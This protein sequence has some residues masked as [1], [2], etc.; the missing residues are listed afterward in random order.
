MGAE[1]CSELRD[2]AAITEAIDQYFH[3]LDSGRYE[4]LDSAFWPD[5]SISYD[6][7]RDGTYVG[8]DTITA[9]VRSR[10]DLRAHTSHMKGSFTVT[11]HGDE[12]EADIFGTIFLI[13]TDGGPDASAL[14]RGVHYRD[15]LERRNGAWRIRT[16]VHR[17]L[18]RFETA[19]A[20]LSV[21]EQ[22]GREA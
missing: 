22:P 14:I 2:R 11:L 15:R 21:V 1:E 9:Y 6:E 17:A 3:C 12:A 8:L 4:D 13:A 19:A 5:A 10:Q 18:W 20:I 16:R 7:G